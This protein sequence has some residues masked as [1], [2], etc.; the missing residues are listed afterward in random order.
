MLSL[1]LHIPLSAFTLLASLQDLTA[2]YN[3]LLFPPR[4]VSFQF[5]KLVASSLP[6]LQTVE[7]F[8]YILLVEARHVSMH[9]PVVVADV[10]LCTPIGHRA[11]PEWWREFVRLLK[12]WRGFDKKK[13]QHGEK[14][15]R[16]PV[17]T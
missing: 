11:K 13:K 5:L 10:A 12:L 7:R 8:F 4:G 6:G 3:F 15:R 16:S 2:A 9:V 1:P 17:S 14:D